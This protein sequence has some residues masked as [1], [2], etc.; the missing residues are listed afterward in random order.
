MHD[1]PR[2]ISATFTTFSIELLN[3]VQKM[4]KG[5][6]PAAVQQELAAL[7]TYCALME[8]DPS[9]ELTERTKKLRQ[10][11]FKESYKRRRAA[12]VNSNIIDHIYNFGHGDQLSLQEI[13]VSSSAG[14]SV[15]SSH[16]I[17]Y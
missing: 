4:G 8:E 9:I 16:P 1:C 6:S 11:S 7:E 10:A 3:V 15:G 5:M 12:S 13:T 17:S 14:S 2:F